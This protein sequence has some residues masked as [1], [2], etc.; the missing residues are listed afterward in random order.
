MASSD[1]PLK[2]DVAQVL[3]DKNPTLARLTPGL[4]IRYLRRIV[5]ED[6]VNYVLTHFSHLPPVDF[7]RATLGYMQITYEA[8]GLGRLD[9]AGRYLFASNHPFG[10][11]DGMM[12]A[13]EVSARF[14]DVRLLVNDLLMHLRPLAPIFVPVNKHGRQSSAYAEAMRRTFDSAVP[15]I[16]FPAGLCSRRRKGVV[17]DLCWKP[18]FVKK[19]IESKRDIV[20]VHFDGRLSGFFYRLANL[21]TRLGIKA[22]I[23]MLYLADEMFAQHGRHFD[24]TVGDPIGWQRLA[25]GTPARTWASRIEEIAYGLKK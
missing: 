22:N 8:H 16:T 15:V 21:R 5:H 4:L 18:S 7:V 24:I 13:A 20:P 11:M 2:V 23:E 9:P 1:K 25:D 19:A 12:L 3:R 14:G 6:E 10:G 17:R